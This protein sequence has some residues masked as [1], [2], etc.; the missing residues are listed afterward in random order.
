LRRGE[1]AAVN[2]DLFF[3][4]FGYLA[5]APNGVKKLRE[6]ILQLAIQ[7]KLVPQDPNDEPASVLLAKIKEEKIKK[8]EP[9]PAVGSDEIPYDLPKGWVWTR[10]GELG[11]TQTGTTPKTGDLESFGKDYPFIK[12]ADIYPN[13]IDYNNDGLSELGVSK[14][15]RI[16]H[17]GSILMVCI[18]TIGKSNIIEK[19]CSF[20]QQ[21]N[22]ITPYSLISAYFLK[23]AVRSTFFQE[24]AWNASSSTTLSILNKSKWEKLVLPLPPLSEQ[25]RIVAKVDQLMALCDELETRQQKK[26]QTL[27]TLS[28]AAL[29]R[30]LTAREPDDFINTWR[31]LRDNFDFLYTAPETITKL[32][33]SI[34][35]LAVQGKLVP[36]NPNNEPSSALLAKIKA[37]KEKLIKEKKIKK[38]PPLPPVSPD[39]TPHK[40]PNGWEWVRLGDIAEKLGSGS[41]P[42]GGKSVYIAHGVKFLRSQNIWNEGLKL[43]DVAFISHQIHNKM[44]GTVVRPK[45]IL[46]N[47]TGASIGRSAVVPDDF[48]EANVSQHVAIVRMINKNIARYIHLCIISPIVQDTIMNVQVGVSREGL[49]MSKLEYFLLP[50]PPLAEQLRIVTKVEQLMK[51]CDELESKLIKSQTKSERLVEI[52]VKTIAST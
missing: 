41:T 2:T 8:A 44:S 43:N 45:D 51:L 12:P 46:L 25:H 14:C 4:N 18:G 7:G 38:T 6:L 1:A 16:A 48:D 49:S 21:I 47:I 35:Q 33:Q 36:Q 28:N 26:K 32:R 34:L 50:L 3:A 13:H 19:S 52:A 22:V 11:I 23:L 17:S 29:D 42:L 31:F 9:L 5:D 24:A 39:E 10:L 37:D 30:L 15:G 27:V 20:N 40:L